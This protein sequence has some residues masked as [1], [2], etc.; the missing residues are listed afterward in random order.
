[1][2]KLIS[3]CIGAFENALDGVPGGLWNTE[4]VNTYMRCHADR[5][6]FKLSVRC[7]TEQAAS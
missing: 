5:A 4:L 1:M 6:R 7:W 2:E 3:W